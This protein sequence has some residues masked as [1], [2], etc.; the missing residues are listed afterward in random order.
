M[1]GRQGSHTDVRPFLR[2]AS[3]FNPGG[4]FV[5]DSGISNIQQPALHGVLQQCT[6]RYYLDGLPSEQDTE[7]DQSQAETA[8]VTE[9]MY[10]STEI[11]ASK[12]RSRNSCITGMTRETFS[13]SMI[14]GLWDVLTW[15][16]CPKSFRLLVAAEHEWLPAPTVL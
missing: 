10:V 1:E 6:S 16:Q 4:S 9:T 14:A 3:S 13:S 12:P 7:I 8:V 2:W 15:H 5:S 11:G